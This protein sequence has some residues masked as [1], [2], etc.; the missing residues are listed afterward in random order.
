MID[1]AKS[2]ILRNG[3]D[4][5]NIVLP[6]RLCRT[7]MLSALVSKVAKAP[8]DRAQM[9]AILLQAARSHVSRALRPRIKP[10]VSFQFSNSRRL[11]N[12]LK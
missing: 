8:A 6:S 7:V 1:I 11:I 5:C 10:S 9:A 2:Y 12:F 3:T 4:P